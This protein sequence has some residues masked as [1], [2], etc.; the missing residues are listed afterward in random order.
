MVR[1]VEKLL[2]GHS[3][4]SIDCGR[5]EEVATG[6]LSFADIAVLYRT[7]AQAPALVEALHRSGMPFQHRS[8]SILID[9]PGVAELADALRQR[10]HTGSL[11]E[12][13]AAAVTALSAAVVKVPESAF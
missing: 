7:E 10:Q 4:F 3:F 2:G 6:N 8:H 1:S 9:H 13:L 5:A 12:Q 11:R